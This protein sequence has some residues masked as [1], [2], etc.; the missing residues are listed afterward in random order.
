MTIDLVVLVIGVLRTLNARLGS[1]LSTGLHFLLDLLF[2]ESDET[3]DSEIFF[4]IV[5]SFCGSGSVSG[6]AA[7]EESSSSVI[8]LSCNNSVSF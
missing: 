4:S 8:M 2:P 7:A 6:S 5:G 1:N 3:V